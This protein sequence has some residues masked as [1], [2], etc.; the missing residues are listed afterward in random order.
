MNASPW[1]QGFGP[2]LRKELSEWLRGGGALA[3]AVVL[4][5]LG[6]LDTLATRIDELAGGSPTPAQLDPTYNIV[7]A[8]FDQWI[9]FGAI[10]ATIGLLLSER[11]TGTL[12]WTL[13]KPISRSALFLAKWVVATGVLIVFGL[14]VPLAISSGVALLAY[15]G[16]PDIGSVAAMTAW[17]ACAAA[18]VV[19]FNLALATRLQS[20]GA[21]GA[22]GFAVA[23]VP[24][25]ANAFLPSLAGVWPTSVAAMANLVAAG[26]APYLPTV[27][28]WA[29]SL[30]VA[31]ASGLIL[32]SRED[33]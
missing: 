12:A 26:E 2:F 32:F 6:C 18:F 3:T 30:S 9:V 21:I 1:Y 25:V 17:L 22:I 23:V 28:G 14:V 8:Q 27:V 4:S 29:A 7:G 19:A 20:Q 16:L 11:G 15:G 10:F 33:M 31:G 5:A 24:Y 13:S